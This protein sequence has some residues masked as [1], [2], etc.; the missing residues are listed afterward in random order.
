[1]FFW[2]KTGGVAAAH[3][4]AAC[5]SRNRPR[6]TVA[7][8]G[9]RLGLLLRNI[10]KSEI[11]QRACLREQ[12]FGRNGPTPPNQ[13]RMRVVLDRRELLKHIPTAIVTQKMF[14]YERL[15]CCM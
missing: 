2:V 10:L 4:L 6:E 8:L 5:F 3:L 14:R 15:Y 1:M 9:R 12:I 13:R 11:R 7:L